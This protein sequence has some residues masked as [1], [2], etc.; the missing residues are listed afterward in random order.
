[1]DSVRFGIVGAGTIGAFHAEAI[2]A[3]EGARLTAVFDS[4][5]E[6]SRDFGAKHGIESYADLDRF[7]AQAP[8][9]AVTVATPTGLHASVA[10]P[11]ARAGK[12]VL[13]EKPIGTTAEKA[14]SIVDACRQAGVILSPVFQNRFG[15]GAMAMKAIARPVRSGCCS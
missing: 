14:Q 7:L 3:V 15:A 4:V 13:C 8:I 10:I 6:R 9:D 11:A 2:R 12:H 5:A 1:M